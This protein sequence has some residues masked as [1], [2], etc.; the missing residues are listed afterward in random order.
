MPITYLLILLLFFSF[1]Y[2]LSLHFPTLP[3]PSH[4]PISSPL[5][6]TYIHCHSLAIIVHDS[7]WPNNGGRGFQVRGRWEGQERE[8]EDLIEVGWV[9]WWADRLVGA[10]FVGIG[11]DGACST[12]FFLCLWCY[13]FACLSVHLSDVSNA[14]WIKLI[15]NVIMKV[16]F[17]NWMSGFLNQW[18][19]VFLFRGRECV[20]I[21]LSSY[22]AV[23]LP[24]SSIVFELCW[25]RR[26]RHCRR[27]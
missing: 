18:S 9:G 19:L 11:G 23:Q 21:A 1:A 26:G 22:L 27:C 16:G 2:Y 20:A 13:L 4:L 3:L 6:P 24:I 5:K 7:P 25:L 17:S 12:C 8:N 14:A 10:G 15:L